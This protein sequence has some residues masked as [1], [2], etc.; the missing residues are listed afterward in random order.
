M[1]PRQSSPRLGRELSARLPWTRRIGEEPETTRSTLLDPVLRHRAL[2][3]RPTVLS[4]P[5][6]NLANRVRS[7]SGSDCVDLRYAQQERFV[8]RRS[9]DRRNLVV[10]GRSQSL[11]TSTKQFCT[12]IRRC[13]NFD[14]RL[15]QFATQGVKV[16]RC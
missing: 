16:T 13:E 12:R 1:W 5:L 9:S 2:S 14:T 10:R 15:G 3:I 8:E 4:G 7:A 6:D 11:V